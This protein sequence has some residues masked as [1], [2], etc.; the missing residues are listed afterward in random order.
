[1]GKKTLYFQ[2]KIKALEFCRFKTCPRSC[3]ICSTQTKGV[4]IY[5]IWEETPKSAICLNFSKVADWM[6]PGVIRK[7]Q[8]KRKISGKINKDDLVGEA[9]ILGGCLAVFISY[10]QL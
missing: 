3:F 7:G 4:F 1:M 8:G 10:L 5:F 9:A 2:T 6:H